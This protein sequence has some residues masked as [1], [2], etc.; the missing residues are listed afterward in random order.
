M[1]RWAIV[2]D[3]AVFCATKKILEIKTV[4]MALVLI[5]SAFG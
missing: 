5:L 3:I 4:Q 2:E 1:G